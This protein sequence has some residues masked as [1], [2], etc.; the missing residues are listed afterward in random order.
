ML[1]NQSRTIPTRNMPKAS[2]SLQ[3]LVFASPVRPF[4]PICQ[5]VTQDFSI[6]QTCSQFVSCFDQPLGLLRISQWLSPFATRPIHR[7][8]GAVGPA[9]AARPL[10]R[11]RPGDG[12]DGSNEGSS[13]GGRFCTAADGWI[14]HGAGP[15]CTGDEIEIK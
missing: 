12:G 9:P 8:S 5:V 1:L 4:R 15:N 13:D 3:K 6:F 14:L 2:K 10:G 11:R 7:W